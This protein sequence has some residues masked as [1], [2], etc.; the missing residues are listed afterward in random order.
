MHFD[1]EYYKRLSRKTI[2]KLLNG[3][4]LEGKD[5]AIYP[6]GRIGQIFK[7]V[8]NDEFGIYEKILVD[9][10]AATKNKA[11]KSLETLTSE[12]REQ[13]MFVIASDNEKLFK[14]IRLDLRRNVSEINCFDMFDKVI[15]NRD[16]RIETLRLNAER[17]NEYHIEGN[18]AEVGVWK[19]KFAKYINKYF[20]GRK[21][22]LFDTFEGFSN[23]QLA[24]DIDERWAKELTLIDENFANPEWEHI[25]EDFE[26]PEDCIIKKGYFPETANGI[27]DTFC[28]VSLDVDVYAGTKNGLEFFWPKLAD[29]GM[30]MI[31]DYNCNSCPGVANAVNEFA[32]EHRV[33]PI[34]L[35]DRAGSAIL[36]KQ[37]TR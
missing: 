30:I 4:Y 29:G 7:T 19:G 27:E 37:G 36:L 15:Q 3:K 9:N 24:K 6:F 22:Y 8:L 1:E 12:E 10:K 21:L 32:K 13:C 31:H 34:C 5:I 20:N 18:V 11:I 2:E 33:F 16:T 23:Q 17:I 28:F 14:E 35:S 26:H 25:L